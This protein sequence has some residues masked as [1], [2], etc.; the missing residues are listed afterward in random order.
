[1]QLCSNVVHVIRR[2]MHVRVRREM[3]IR[4]RRE[5]HVRERREIEH[6]RYGEHVKN[7]TCDLTRM[8]FSFE[9]K[10]L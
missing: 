9:T 10:L 8:T 2:E 5:M 1:M 6:V 3:H 7:M 4:V